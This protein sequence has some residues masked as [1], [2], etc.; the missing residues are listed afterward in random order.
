ML[1]LAVLAEPA[2][3]QCEERVGPEVG[4][5]ESVDHRSAGIEYF[6]VRVADEI[7][8]RVLRRSL[9]KLCAEVGPAIDDIPDADGLAGCD[10]T[11]ILDVISHLILFLSE[12]LLFSLSPEGESEFGSR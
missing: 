10:K 11:P 8:A 12:L 1:K 3:F 7:A 6:F 9:R 4:E 5:L 2:A